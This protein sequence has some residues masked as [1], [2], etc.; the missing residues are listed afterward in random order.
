MASPALAGHTGTL[1]SD[2]LAGRPSPL[3]ACA[4]RQLNS[5]PSQMP[6]PWP[7]DR[8][9]LLAATPSQPLSLPTPSS[10]GRAT[11]TS[12]LPGRPHS[13]LLLHCP[14]SVHPVL[15]QQSSH[16]GNKFNQLR[17][18]H[19]LCSPPTPLPTEKGPG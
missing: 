7:S 16:Q 14:Q 2:R 3:S 5:G 19:Y 15:S 1:E 10:W 18:V 12:S 6:M 17:W 8:F 11:W 4:S 9:L 13:H